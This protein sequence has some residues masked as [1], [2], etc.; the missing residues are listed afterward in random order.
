M[1]MGTMLGRCGSS[2]LTGPVGF[3]PCR[4]F[5]FASRIWRWQAIW[6]LGILPAN[7]EPNNA[8]FEPPRD[9]MA[10][11]LI[12]SVPRRPFLQWPFS[13]PQ[14]VSP[15]VR[16][17]L[18][19]RLAAPAQPLPDSFPAARPS[20]ARHPARCYPAPYV[21]SAGGRPASSLWFAS[22]PYWKGSSGVAAC[23][24]KHEISGQMENYTYFCPR[25]NAELHVDSTEARAKGK[26]RQCGVLVT[27]EEIISQQT[28][29]RM[30]RRRV[31]RL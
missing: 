29:I 14:R 4:P 21:Q 13:W 3:T 27:A 16:C 23:P 15:H 25:C 2:T 8:V 24:V 19:I 11:I 20:W 28:A 5:Y 1:I 22:L 9:R 10:A 6:R 31:Q 17:H 12:S 30:E 18:S 26:C 7:R